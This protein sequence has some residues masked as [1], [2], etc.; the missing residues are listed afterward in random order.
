MWICD[1]DCCLWILQYCAVL[2]MW[3]CSMTTDTCPVRKYRFSRDHSGVV[4]KFV[5]ESICRRL[6]LNAAVRRMIPHNWSVK[7]VFHHSNWL[8]NRQY[9][10]PTAGG[11]AFFVAAAHLW[12]SLPS[13][14]TA[15]P[16]LS[17]FCCRLKWHLFHRRSQRCLGAWPRPPIGVERKLHNR[18]SCAEGTNICESLMF[19]NCECE[20]D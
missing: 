3:H 6:S 9:V 2:C 11:R 5:A 7:C 8:W 12:N 19:S 4:A 17:V 14:V 1:C 18:F 10:A 20:C 16:S 15:A 13:H